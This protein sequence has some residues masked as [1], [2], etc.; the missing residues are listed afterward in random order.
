MKKILKKIFLFV[1]LIF[2][3]I[4]N[5]FACSIPPDILNRFYIYEENNSLKIK[6]S[7][8]IWEDFKPKLDADFKQK[9]WKNLNPENIN[10]F[11]EKF[12]K[13]NINL[14][15]NEKNIELNF[16]SVKFFENFSDSKPYFEIDFSTNFKS[17]EEKNFFKIIYEKKNFSNLTSLIHTYFYSEIEENL[18]FAWYTKIWE[19]NFDNYYFKWKKY[20]ILAYISE[21]NDKEIVYNLKINDFWKAEKNFSK[22]NI[23]S[24][25][26]DEN[27]LLK[28]NNNNTFES[29]RKYFEDFLQRELSIFEIIF[30][31]IFAII[32][33]ALHG[34]LPGHSKSIIWAYVIDKKSKNKEIFLLILSITLTHTFFIFLLAFLIQLFHI[35]VWTSTL[36]IKYFSSFLYILFGIYFTYFALKNIFKKEKKQ[37]CS[38]ECCENHEKIEK[39]SSK[40]TFLIWM[41]FGCNPCLDALVLFIFALSI[42]NIFFAS[43]II[44]AFSLWLWL[45]LGILAI[46]ASKWYNFM[47]NKKGQKIKIFLNIFVLILWI[48]IIWTWIK[49]FL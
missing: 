10:I 26:I 36:Y 11:I 14:T 38:C 40:K 17:L 16:E 31:F 24:Q 48:F 21:E 12:L 5:T 33:W 7:L 13:E 18:D 8:Y 25:K 29:W 42:W 45:M 28:A 46:F 20:W 6:Y 4:A 30:W 27:P 22:N 2:F 49:W 34:L 37:T 15:L 1:I 35:W 23:N 39:K 19:D 47:S 32:F 41:I 44:L 43:L 9:T 3:S